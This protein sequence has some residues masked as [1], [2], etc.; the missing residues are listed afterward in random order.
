MKAVYKFSAEAKA[1]LL[2]IVEYTLDRFGV[3]QVHQ[4]VAK[5]ELCAVNMAKNKPGTRTLMDI[6][7]DLRFIHC[8]HH[9]I[10]GLL[11]SD[12]SLLIIAIL[13]ERMDIEARVIARLKSV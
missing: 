12:G 6:D 10:F 3:G 5:L 7:R 2:S 9:Y 11:Q 4:Y 1:D 13:H 8:A